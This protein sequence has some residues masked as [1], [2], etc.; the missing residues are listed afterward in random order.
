MSTRPPLIL[1]SLWAAVRHS[2]DGPEWIDTNAI[3]V[4]TAHV[5]DLFEIT[6]RDIPDWAKLHPV[7]RIV[8]ITITENV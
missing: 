5:R 8:P 3:G 6:D 4:N 1:K 2:P 7:L